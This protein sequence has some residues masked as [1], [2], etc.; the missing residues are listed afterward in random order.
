MGEIRE[1]HSS[2]ISALLTSNVSNIIISICYSA[3]MLRVTPMSKRSSI[4]FFNCA[5]YSF[6]ST[7]FAEEI[8]MP[9]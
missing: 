1:K 9:V 8:P 2:C 4:N 3:Y 6:R 7:I 5:N